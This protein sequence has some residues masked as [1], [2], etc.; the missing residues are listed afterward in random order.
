MKS[1]IKTIPEQNNSKPLGIQKIE[2]QILFGKS[3]PWSKYFKALLFF[4][5]DVNKLY[6]ENAMLKDELTKMRSY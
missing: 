3:G 2:K 4:G 1:K 6:I 5:I